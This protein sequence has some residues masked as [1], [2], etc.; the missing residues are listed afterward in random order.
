[1]TKQDRAL[2]A[3]LSRKARALERARAALQEQAFGAAERELVD[4]LT[5]VDQHPADFADV[6]FERELS[7]T[8]LRV[9]E[10]EEAQ[11]REAIK[12][13]KA[14]LYGICAVCGRPIGKERL[15]A[16]PEAT[17]CI[18]DQARLERQARR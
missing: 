18:E 4:E 6:T 7:E 10:Q 11:I 15:K 9:L 14:G 16:R 12:R 17:L 2:V 13:A 8:E 5:D 3:R 1:M